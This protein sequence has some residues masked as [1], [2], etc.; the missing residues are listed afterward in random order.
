MIMNITIIGL[1]VIGGSLGIAI[2]QNHSA[3]IVTGFDKKKKLASALK[4]DAIDFGAVSLSAAVHDADIIFLCTPVHSILDLI[5]HIAALC[6]TNAIV[7]DVGST[8]VEIEKAAKRYFRSK[9]IFVGGHPMAGSEGKGIEYADGLL[10]Q[11]ATYVLCK[12]KKEDCYRHEQ[13]GDMSV[14]KSEQRGKRQ[15][16][17]SKSNRTSRSIKQDKLSLLSFR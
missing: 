15:L 4:R 1:G 8:K 7:T 10:F 9:G 5:P 17:N 6:K 2:K 13:N 11:N 12:D 16:G 14:E 3:V